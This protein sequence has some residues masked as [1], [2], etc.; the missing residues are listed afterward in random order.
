M[1]LTDADYQNFISKNKNQYTVDEETRNVEYAIFD[2]VPSGADTAN[3]YQ[4]LEDLKIDFE[5]KPTT[6]EDSLFA[7]SNGGALPNVYFKTDQLPE[8]TKQRILS[9][10]NGQVFGPY[11][12]Q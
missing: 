4:T 12:D 10:S 7:A 1:E 6:T 8:P 2:V 9:M 3:L 5:A 11:E